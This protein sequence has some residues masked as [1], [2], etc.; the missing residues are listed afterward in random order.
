MEAEE[1]GKNK[2]NS[3]LTNRNSKKSHLTGK[4]NGKGKVRVFF[5]N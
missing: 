3:L 4:G 1:I 2:A 5:W